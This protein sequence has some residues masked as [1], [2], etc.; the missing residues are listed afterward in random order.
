MVVAVAVVVVVVVVTVVA[1]VAVAVVTGA[2]LTVVVAVVEGGAEPTVEA[3]PLPLPP[4]SPHLDISLLHPVSPLA[5]LSRHAA[6]GQPRDRHI[7]R[8]GL[9]SRRLPVLIYACIGW[10]TA[11]GGGC[12]ARWGKFL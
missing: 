4:P 5:K 10:C 11:L 7:F 8:N 12:D 6:H 1:A 9:F 2:A 3:L